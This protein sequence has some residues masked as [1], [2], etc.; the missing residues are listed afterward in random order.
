MGLNMKLLYDSGQVQRAIKRIFKICKGRRIA[1]TAFVG[2]KAIAYLP[3][4][5]GIELVCWPKAGGTDPNSVR[6]LIRRGVKAYFVPNLHM[7][8]Y[9]TQDKGAVLTSANL[10]K[11]AL[12]SGG[13]KEIGIFLDSDEVNITRIWRTIQPRPVLNG[14]LDKL[15]TH[16]DYLK[17]HLSSPVH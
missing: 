16:R 8:L 12:G 3:K 13:L 1:I 6:D 14:S 15:K 4:P 7:K 2:E 17:K 9:W 10:S 11:S 5:K